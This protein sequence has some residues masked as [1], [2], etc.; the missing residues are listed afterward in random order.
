MNA[1][2]AREDLLGTVPRQ[3]RSAATRKRLLDATV[4]L[5]MEVGYNGLT[6]RQVALRAGVSSGAQQHH[7]PQKTTLVAAA[8]RHLIDAELE[9]FAHDVDAMP[10]GRARVDPLLDW[11]FESYRRARFHVVVEIARAANEHPALHAVLDD[12][13]RVVRETIGALRGEIFGEDEAPADFGE[14]VAMAYSVMRGLA[15]LTVLGH[16]DHVLKRQWA[17][18]R[19]RLVALLSGED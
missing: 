14:R 18:A 5:L 1:T 17:F 2:P 6:T 12:E 10:R 3:D 8:V 4:E 15:L 19:P 16:P 7:F 13:E 9:L 11:L